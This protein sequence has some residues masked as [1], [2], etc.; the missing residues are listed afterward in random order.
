MPRKILVFSIGLLILLTGVTWIPLFAQNDEIIVTVG[1]EEWQQ[2][3]F[4]D[5][6]FA[7]FQW[8]R[9]LQECLERQSYASI[10]YSGQPGEKRRKYDC[11]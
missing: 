5:E 8:E 2:D 11:C 1:I 3:V 6:L 4:N 10:Y 7:L 9:D